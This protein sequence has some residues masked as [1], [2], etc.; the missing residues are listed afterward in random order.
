MCVSVLVA[1]D[2][3]LLPRGLE[4]AVRKRPELE[5]VGTADDGREALARTRALALRMAGLDVRCRGSTGRRC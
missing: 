3:S 2:H 5:L 4:R 1:D